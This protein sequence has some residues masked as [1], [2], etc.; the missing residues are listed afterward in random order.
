MNYLHLFLY[1]IIG[2]TAIT[3]IATLG[4]ATSR[5]YQFNYSVFIILSILI[6]V[7]LGYFIS[8]D[9]E[10][11]RAVLVNGLLGL[12]DSTVGFWLSIQFKANT[13]ASDK[14][15]AALKGKP[16]IAIIMVILSVFFAAVGQW[17]TT[18]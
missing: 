17:L 5:K 16:T 18:I 8:K 3:I 15:I 7:S 9:F 6:Y 2:I 12:Y 4:S 11:K 1:F 13:G 14:E 10:F